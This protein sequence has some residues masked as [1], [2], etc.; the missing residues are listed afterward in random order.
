MN[1]GPNIKSKSDA[2]EYLKFLRRI[3][4]EVENWPA[5]KKVDGYVV[6][7]WRLKRDLSS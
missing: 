4:R 1:A 5:Y 3:R 2:K 6:R 7:R